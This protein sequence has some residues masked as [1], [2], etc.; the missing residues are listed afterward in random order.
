MSRVVKFWILYACILLLPLAAS[1]ADQF[2]TDVF[3]TSDGS[4]RI[5]FLGH[6]SLM[7][8]F[9]DK[10]IYIDP[11]SHVA[12][13]SKMPKADIILFTH[14]H[15]DHFD[16]EALKELC[17]ENTLVV[18]PE[19]CAAK[20]GEGIIMKN[21]DVKII[22]GL[23]IEGVPAYNIVEKRASGFPYHLK[24]IGNGYVITFGDKRVYIA[25]DTEKIPEMDELSEI[26]I[27][28]LPVEP[29]DTMTV[30][31]AAD[32]VKAIKPKIFYPYRYGDTDI[33]ELKELLK[34]Q[35]ETEVRIRKM[36]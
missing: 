7:M 9:H 1:G 28:F 36:E 24:G 21:E 8:D 29:P 18:M 26:D 14:E 12:D 17:S 4:L 34:D 31:M 23:K 6:A 30:E 20:Y 3:R 32:T 15:S 27:A 22:Q 35:P 13:F 16:L 19:I 2:E 10:H 33:N 5:S 25:G 11:W